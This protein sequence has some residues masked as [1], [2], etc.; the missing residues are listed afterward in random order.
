MNKYIDYGVKTVCSQVLL[1]ARDIDRSRST[2][3]IG[4]IG[5]YQSLC[6]VQIPTNVVGTEESLAHH[7]GSTWHYSMSVRRQSAVVYLD[8]IAFLINRSPTISSPQTSVET[9]EHCW[10]R[11]KV[12]RLI[13]LG[14]KH[15]LF[16]PCDTTEVVGRYGI[17]AENGTR[18]TKSTNQT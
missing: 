14:G 1:H 5:L 8:D 7:P 17:I 13:L 11:I 15:P 16:G 10:C 4:E 12:E 9:T 6:P 3:P 18:T 2:K